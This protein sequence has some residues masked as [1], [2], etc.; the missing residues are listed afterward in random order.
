MLY[1]VGGFSSHNEI[2]IIHLRIM[3]KSYEQKLSSFVKWESQAQD[4]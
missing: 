1:L 2:L 3:K 4:S